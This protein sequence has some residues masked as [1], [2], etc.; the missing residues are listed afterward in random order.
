MEIASS[1]DGPAIETVQP[2]GKTTSEPDRFILTGQLSLEKLAPGDYV[3]RAIIKHGD[4]P[5][6]RVFATLRKL[7]K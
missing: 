7:A 4:G 3:V 2:G 6:G 5:E 1:M